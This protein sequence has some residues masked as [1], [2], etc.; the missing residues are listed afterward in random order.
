MGNTTIL[1][2]MSV[3]EWYILG[4]VTLYVVILGRDT[5][6]TTGILFEMETS[7]RALP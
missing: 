7:T 3:V 4:N 2:I 1:G 5:A 6:I